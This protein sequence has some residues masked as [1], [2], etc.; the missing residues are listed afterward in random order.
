MKIAPLESARTL[1]IHSV[2]QNYAGYS[3]VEHQTWS[4][5][6]NALIDAL[7][8]RAVVPYAEALLMCGLRSDRLPHLAEIN[9]S[10][11]HFGWLSTI[12]EGF[13]PPQTFMDFQA[14]CVLPITRH[15][16][17]ASQQAYTP[18]PDIIHEA[19]GHLPMLVD[20]NY[21]SF[22]KRFGEKGRTL[23]FGELDHRVFALQKDYAEHLAIDD[24]DENLVR[25]LECSLVELR[26]AQRR[27]V[28][29]ACLISRFHWWTVEYG[30]I[31]EDSKLYGAGLLSSSEEAIASD[32][33]PRIPLSLDCLSYDYEIS[34]M[35][36]QLFV[37]SDWNH[38]NDELDRFFR[39]EN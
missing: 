3:V 20:G 29:P 12:V 11:R 19:A 32:E 15:V 17:S 34:K 10:L 8:D 5:A 37:A 13:I 27:A 25:D 38:L 36:P 39:R 30:L 2:C 35:Q 16:R 22:M 23:R 9:R 14:N 33:T 18:I 7:E 4:N 1:E 28:T 21:R 31:G 26:R 24:P 6:I